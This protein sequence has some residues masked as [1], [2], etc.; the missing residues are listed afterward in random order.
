MLLKIGELAKRTGLT[1]RTL[2]HYDA[3]GLLQPS[4]RS[5]A[6]YRLYNRTDIERL[7]RIQALRRLDLSLAEIGEL[8]QGGGADLESVIEQQILALDRQV[9]RASELRERL[10]EL[11]S[12]LKRNIEPDLHKWLATLEMMAIYDRY[13]SSDDLKTMRAMKEQFREDSDSL[14]PPL[15][16]ELRALMAQGIAPESGAAQELA[17]RWMA[18]MQKTMGGDARLILKLDAMHRNEP[19]VQTQTGVDGELIDYVSRAG[20]HSRWR[21]YEKYLSPEELAAARARKGP[22]HRLWTA[23]I[24]EVRQQMEQGTS[25][26]SE[27][28]QPLALRWLQ[29]VH[30]TWGS[31]PAVLAK[32][33]TASQNEPDIFIGT[34]IDSAMLEFIEKAFEAH[35]DHIKQQ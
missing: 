8:L 4:A 31:D 6:G 13:F 19:T 34:G 18:L 33:R 7:H 17:G 29:L 10:R 22:D 1:V 27:R 25:P 2:H 21:F 11:Q 5:D 14:W 16:A 3:I 20:A 30:A 23:L 32:V 24:A 35:Q 12:K 9:A 26:H 28:M 15:I